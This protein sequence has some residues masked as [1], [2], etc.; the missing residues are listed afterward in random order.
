VHSFADYVSDVEALVAKLRAGAGD[1]PI[2]IVAHSTGALVTALWGLE[3][4]RGVAGVV[5]SQPYLANATPAPALKVLAA[6]IIGKVVPFLPVSTGFGP[7][8]LTREPDMQA[9]TSMDPLYLRKTTPRFFEEALRTHA[10]VRSR[11]SR[12]SN[13]LLVLLGTGGHRRLDRRE[14]TSRRA[15][16]AGASRDGRWGGRRRGGRFREERTLPV[17]PSEDSH[18]PNWCAPSAT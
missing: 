13:P 9:W 7:E 17:R 14:G 4:A 16:A 18:Q 1:R 8:H 11:A 10:T 2:F 3:P 12:F 6:R 15:G 5:L